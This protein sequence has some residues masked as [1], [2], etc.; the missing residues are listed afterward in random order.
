ML[1][2][3][4]YLLLERNAPKAL[5]DVYS[6]LSQLMNCS[7]GIED[8]I[9]SKSVASHYKVQQVHIEARKRMEE[10]GEEAPPVGGRMP[11]IIVAQ[12][13]GGHLSLAERAE[14]PDYV[15]KHNLK[16]DLEYYLKASFSALR[17]LYQSFDGE[18]L[19]AI[20]STM[21]NKA[22]NQG[23]KRLLHETSD[24][25]LATALTADSKAKKVKKEE[26][27]TRALF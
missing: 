21:L 25:S 20:L 11:F 17:K 9:V 12:K 19:E 24:E 14:H 15:L 6:T 5:E 22:T 2:I 1:R 13:R 27:K 8:L 3:L 10:R 23:S 16:P 18:K 26:R 4:D 7:I